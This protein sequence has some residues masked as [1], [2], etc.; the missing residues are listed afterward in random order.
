MP[1]QLEMIIFALS[2]TSKASLPLK[3]T[4]GMPVSALL[5]SASSPVGCDTEQVEAIYL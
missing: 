3:A 1:E 4:Q 2:C 5:A